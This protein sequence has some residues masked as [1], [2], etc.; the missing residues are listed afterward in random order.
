V[1]LQWSN[2]SNAFRYVVQGRAC[3][4]LPEPVAVKILL[5]G[6][7]RQ[8][9]Q[10]MTVAQLLAELGLAERR[11]AVEVNQEIVPRSRHGEYHLK[12]EDR[13]EVVRAIGGGTWQ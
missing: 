10:S 11:V 12:D 6:E 2:D 3:T 8:F 4:R 7:E 1:A 5:N 9:P 13:V